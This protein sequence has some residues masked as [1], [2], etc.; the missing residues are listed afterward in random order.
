[1]KLLETIKN[2]AF[3]GEYHANSEKVIA[4]LQQL[5]A[6]YAKAVEAFHQII[7]I[8]K[9]IESG[10]LIYNAKDVIAVATT[11]LAEIRESEAGK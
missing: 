2:N 4:D 3:R 11:V 8:S 5:A 6:N 1:M 10:S 7:A 9:M